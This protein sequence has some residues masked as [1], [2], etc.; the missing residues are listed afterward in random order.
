M[1]YRPR[2]HRARQ[3]RDGGI[4]SCPCCFHS[5]AYGSSFLVAEFSKGGK[6]RFVKILTNKVKILLDSRE[7]LSGLV[8]VSVDPGSES[9]KLG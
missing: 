3:C 4:R 2:G 5:R 7:L 1:H 9:G 8:D 6:C